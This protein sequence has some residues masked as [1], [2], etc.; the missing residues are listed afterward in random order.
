MTFVFLIGE[1]IGWQELILIGV[2][3][4]VI[5]GPR[6]IPELVKK[7]GK[8]MGELRQATNEFKSTWESEV[9]AITDEV[10]N[11]VKDL[12]NDVKMLSQLESPRPVENSIGRKQGWEDTEAEKSSN[13]NGIE[14]PSVRQV[15]PEQMQL[16]QENASAA[17]EIEEIPETAVAETKKDWL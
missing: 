2:L 10:K 9:S 6:K 14:P 1:S 5:F 3:A 17:D 16:A 13:G 4:L 15:E 8:I 11:E 12:D 7:F